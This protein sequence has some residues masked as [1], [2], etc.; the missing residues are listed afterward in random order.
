MKTI[1]LR[2]NGKYYKAKVDRETMTAYIYYKNKWFESGEFIAE[3]REDKM[4]IEISDLFQVGIQRIKDLKDG[5]KPT[6]YQQ[7]VNREFQ[8]RNN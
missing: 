7:L 6:E 5:T 2:L 8:K 1:E 4:Y 3:L